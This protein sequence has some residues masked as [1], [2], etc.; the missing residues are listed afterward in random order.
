MLKGTETESGVSAVAVEY[1]LSKYVLREETR[2]NGKWLELAHDRLIFPVRQSNNSWFFGTRSGNA[3]LQA[4]HWVA[5][6]RP[7]KGLLRGTALKQVRR[8]V[9]LNPDAVNP[10]LAEFLKASRAQWRRDT[11]SSALWIAFLILLAAVGIGDYFNDSRVA[12]NNDSTQLTLV[13]ETTRLKQT[14]DKYVQE[15]RATA[16]GLPIAQQ[17]G[18]TLTTSIRADSVIEL[19][20]N[21]G[22]RAPQIDTVAYY[23]KPTDPPGT[24]AALFQLGFYVEVPRREINAPTSNALAYSA[25]VGVENVRVVALAVIRAGIT[26][27]MICPAVRNTRPSHVIQVYSTNFADTL[28]QISIDQVLALTSTRQGIN[29]LPR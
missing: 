8:D 16:W 12:K 1:L 25:D 26:L 24:Q 21:G 22:M 17:T 2:R 5:S 18:I 13:A 19:S 20:T 15:V 27:R 10:E 23:A 7:T 4:A 14:V 28:Q 6:G 9:E 11:A 3:H 29:C